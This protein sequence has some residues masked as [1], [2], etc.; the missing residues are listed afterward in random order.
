MLVFTT[1]GEIADD[2]EVHCSKYSVRIVRCVNI[3][4][5]FYLFTLF[6]TTR[7]E[8]ADIATVVSIRSGSSDV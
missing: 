1:R 4:A 7:G 5:L 6:F 8:I 3:I 2:T